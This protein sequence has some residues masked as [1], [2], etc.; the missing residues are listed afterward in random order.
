MINKLKK[1]LVVGGCAAA[2]TFGTN[3]VVAQGR[4]GGGNF[5]PAQF[6]QRILDDTKEALEV[7]DDT[8]WSALEPKVSKVIDARGEV[9]AGTMRGFGRGRN[10][11]RGG[12]NGDDQGNNNT[13]Q[14]RRP[15]G[16]MFGGEPSAAVTA[17]QKAIDDK[18]PTA[19]IKEKLKVVQDEYK[20]KQAALVAAQ[21]DLR[22]VLTPR[23]EAIATLRGL[24]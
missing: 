13:A 11:Q 10:R 3:S 8:E 7:K 17:L 14:Q 4:G 22:S 6:K 18:A 1:A 9:M 2:L 21:E 23:Q 12:G 15:R 20:T 5:D 19:E 16:G 24:L